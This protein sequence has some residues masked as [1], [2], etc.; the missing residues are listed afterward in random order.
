MY[1]R[2]SAPEYMAHNWVAMKIQSRGVGMIVVDRCQ[3]IRWNSL[4]WITGF[5]C[6]VHCLGLYILWVLMP[7]DKF[8]A[9]L[10]VLQEQT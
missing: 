10:T 6:I 8:R 7:V 9:G 2:E 5:L 3:V 4:E 1:L